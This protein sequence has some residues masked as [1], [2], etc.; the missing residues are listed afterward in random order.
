MGN[1][2]VRVNI[3]N[4][5]RGPSHGKSKVYKLGQ[6]FICTEEEANRLGKDITVIET[7]TEPVKP[8]K[9]R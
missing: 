1:V 8:S 7:L 6:E 5:A 4:I 3:S 9:P 2:K